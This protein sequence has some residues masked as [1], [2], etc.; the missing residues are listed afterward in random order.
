MCNVDTLKSANI[1]LS[2]CPEFPGATGK[3]EIY[4]IAAWNSTFV[5]SAVVLFRLD[6]D[7]G[8]DYGDDELMIRKKRVAKWEDWC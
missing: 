7:L 2:K 8:W 5:L 3:M 6:I 1:V 4:G